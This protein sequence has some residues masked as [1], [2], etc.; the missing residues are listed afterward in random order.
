[1]KNV[2]LVFIT[3]ILAVASVAFLWKIP[4]IL[5][6]VLILLFFL[7]HK[8]IPIPRE[9]IWYLLV[10][11]IGAVAENFMILGGSWSYPKPEIFFI[12]GWLPL[13][14]G[15]TGTLFISLYQ[16]LFPPK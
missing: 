2:L 5:S 12:P 8:F 14:W 11:L 13:L 16:G 4:S 6:L 7:K 1:M 3:I 10:G 9:F 15:L